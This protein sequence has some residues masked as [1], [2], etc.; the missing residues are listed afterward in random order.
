MSNKL[1]SF[2]VYSGE[3]IRIKIIAFDML[4]AIKIAEN[5]FVTDYGVRECKEEHDKSINQR[6]GKTA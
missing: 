1:K 6:A 4:H 5:L 3:E 2:E